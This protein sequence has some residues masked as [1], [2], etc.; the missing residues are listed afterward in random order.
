M[1]S[2][3]DINVSLNGWH[4]F[5]THPRSLK[6]EDQ[7]YRVLEVIKAKFPESEGY[8]VSMTY[9]SCSGHSC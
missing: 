9:W 3:Y 6:D 5:G 8:E 1:E 7:A 4:F 2:Y